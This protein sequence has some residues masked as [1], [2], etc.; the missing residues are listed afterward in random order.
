MLHVMDGRN[1]PRRFQRQRHNVEPLVGW[2]KEEQRAYS[3]MEKTATNFGHI[4]EIA[5][6]RQYL[7]RRTS[8]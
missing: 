7:P 6:I 5:A 1:R 2:I 4:I 3:R 8:N